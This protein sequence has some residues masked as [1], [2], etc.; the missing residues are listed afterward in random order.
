LRASSEQRGGQVPGTDREIPLG[1]LITGAVRVGHTVRRPDGPA[2]AAAAG[3]L[4]HL[5]DA[6][7]EGAPRFLGR[8][9]RGRSVVSWIEGWSPDPSQ[10][11]L[12]TA[13]AVR[14]TGALLRRYHQVVA[15][16]RPPVPFP[17]GPPL[18]GPGQLVCHGDIA[19]R[20]TVFA[21]GLPVAFVDWDGAWVSQPLWD[22][23][24]AVW[25][26]APLQPDEALREQGWPGIPDRLER[27]AALADGYQLDR[28][29]RAALP[30]T[31]APMIDACADAITAKARAGQPAFMRLAEAGVLDGMALD[32]RFASRLEASLRQRLLRL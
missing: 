8:D 3:L 10:E 26:F 29:G 11:H 12:V 24:Y 28:A 16:Y 30:A 2:S 13:E 15:G 31:I 18:P 6:G 19:P 20:N 23:G 1:G 5:A 21:D 25:Q 7:F 9:E 17:E 14:A 4:C 27:A 32:A 22:A